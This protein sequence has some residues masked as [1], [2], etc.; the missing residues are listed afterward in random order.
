[1]DQID[2]NES[3]QQIE[4]KDQ[5]K[6]KAKELSYLIDDENYDVKNNIEINSK[7]RKLLTYS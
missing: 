6:D 1:M 2:E 3:D 5:S 7:F 4:K